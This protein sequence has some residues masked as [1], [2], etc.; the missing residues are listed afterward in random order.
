MKYLE[1]PTYGFASG[2]TACRSVRQ[3]CG[4]FITRLGTMVR[5]VRALVRLHRMRELVLCVAVKQVRHFATYRFI[6]MNVNL[7]FQS[8]IVPN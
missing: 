1:V 4:S 3:T 6:Q 5:V 8:T 2:R 7:S